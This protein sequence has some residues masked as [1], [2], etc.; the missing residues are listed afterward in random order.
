MTVREVYDKAVR[1]LADRKVSYQLTFQKDQPANVLVLEDLA[2]FCRA[3]DTAAV[4]GD[5]DRTWALIGRREVWLRITQHLNLSAEQL[6]AIYNADYAKLR[7]DN[8]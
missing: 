6:F 5:H 4:P 3:F 8:T 7:S 2:K 1:Y